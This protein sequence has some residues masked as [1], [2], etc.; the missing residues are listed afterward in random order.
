MA[1][2]IQAGSQ[3][4]RPTAGQ[5]A[6]PRT[7]D[8]SLARAESH[9]P[10]PWRTRSEPSPIFG[11][12]QGGGSGLRRHYPTTRL[13]RGSCGNTCWDLQVRGQAAWPRRG[14]GYSQGPPPQIGSNSNVRHRVARGDRCQLSHWQ[15]PGARRLSPGTHGA[16][17]RAWIGPG[18]PKPRAGHS[19]PVALSPTGLWLS[20]YGNSKYWARVFFDE[21]LCFS[22]CFS[23]LDRCWT[24]F[25]R[26]ILLS[27]LP[28]AIFMFPH[29]SRSPEAS[30]RAGEEGKHRFTLA[31][32]PPGIPS[33]ALQISG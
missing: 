11:W 26:M 21:F 6:P 31:G 18:W 13:G 33:C 23:L 28:I 16:A 27:L 25:A 3:I 2:G 15:S 7:P 29:C 9:P 19:R 4:A 8:A 24:M 30:G 5:G 10:A 14:M 32:N 20:S 1:P 12:R 17:F 22:V